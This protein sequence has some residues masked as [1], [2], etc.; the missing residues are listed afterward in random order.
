MPP[1]RT[2]LL[3]V[4]TVLLGV[5]AACGLGE[6]A[7][8]F[9]WPQRSA[10][11][12]G[13]F[14]QD[15]VA[16]YSLQPGHVDEIRVPEYRTSIRIDPQGYR[17]PE[18]GARD[19]GSARVLA[20]GD[21]FTFGVGVNAEDAWPEVLEQLLASEEALDA[22]VRNGGVGGYGALR[23][24]R[25]LIGRQADWDPQVVVHVLYPGNDLEDSDPDGYLRTPRIS[26]GRMVAAEKGFLTRLRF[27]LRVRSHLYAFLRERL[28]DVYQRTPLADRS[29][30][31][32][33]VGLAV[34]PEPVERAGWP[35]VQSAFREIAAWARERDVRYLVVIAP[36]KYQVSDEAWQ[37]YVRRWGRP[38][39]DFER[40]HAQRVI[41]DW[42]TREG[43][44]W[45]DLLGGF[46]DA[47]REAPGS[48]YFPV[49]AHWTAAGHRLAADLV[50]RELRDRGWIAGA[51][52]D[53]PD[54]FPPVAS[55]PGGGSASDA[56][57]DVTLPR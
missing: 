19:D 48:T 17:V 57:W 41:G 36:V 13:M 8:R 50:R 26:D 14:R 56:F 29:R 1:R 7:L 31:L 12:T 52:G 16:G 22:S 18:Q 15:P 24:A 33:P 53:L 2:L 45:I 34:W 9:F 38:D 4:V 43:I 3:S 46:R 51:G 11:S 25:L 44:A 49:D 30:Y 55:V 32:D 23:S 20:I 37:D 42:L 39:S 28:Y 10:A 35:A 5:A 21:S 6:V 47:E 27:Q 40:D 54:P